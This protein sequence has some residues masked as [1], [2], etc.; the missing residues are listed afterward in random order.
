MSA[1]LVSIIVINYNGVKYL[2]KCFES[3][4]AGAY[5]NIEIIFVDNGS[6]D[7]SVEFVRQNFPQIKIMDNKANLGLSIS[8]NRAAAI[9]KGD[10]LF[11]FNND[12]IADKDMILHLV[13][14]CESNKS[15]GVCGCRTF[16]YDGRRVIN[17]GVSCDIFGYPFSAKKV[18]YVDAGIF[19]RKSVFREISG[20]DE[21]MFLYGEDR[22]ICWRTWLYGYKVVVEKDAFFYHD[23]FCITQDIKD[24]RTTVQKRYLGE[25]NALR[26]ILKN[27][28]FGYLVW[29]LPPFLLIN[30]AEILLFTVLLRLDI[31]NAYLESYKDNLAHLKD[32]MV[33]RKKVQGERK[34]IDRELIRQMYFISA[35]SLL[36]LKWGVPKFKEI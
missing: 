1:P 15:I 27:Y 26:A 11:F 14:R 28:S 7:G 12:T 34:I 25:F 19:I 31:V 2:Q 18:F 20:F 5:Q 22:D 6:S 9:A 36:L 3:L 30:L 29:I 16:S 8:S 32:L 4:Q 13:Q 24:Y 17:T 10:Y 23:S 33:L 35:K 21:Q